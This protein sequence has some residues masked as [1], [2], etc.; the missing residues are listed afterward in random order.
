MKTILHRSLL[1][2]LLLGFAAS[3]ALAQNVVVNGDFQKFTPIDNLWD[4]VD[5]AGFLAGFRRATYATTESGKVGGQEMPISVSFVDVNGDGLPDLITADPAGILRAYINSGTKTEPKFTYAEIIPLFPPQIAK[6]TVYDR[7]W[8]TGPH[9][10]PKIALFDWNHNG[11]ADLLIGNYCGD[12]LLVP[13]TG[14]A[15]GPAFAQPTNYDRVK[16]PL[17]GKRPWG[18]L[19]A[20]CAIDWNK[21]G[22]TDLLIGEGS[23]SA[24][25]VY[26]L[27]NQS[28]GS[29]PKFSDDQR[30]YL[31]YGDG[32]EQLVPTV[33]DYNGDGLPD[34]LVGDRKG[35][36]G[37]YL[38][39]GNWKPGTELPLSEMIRFG[40][41]DTLGMPIAPHAADYNGDGLFDLIIGKSNGRISLALNK[42]TKTQ[43]KFD[44]AVEMRGEKYFKEKI[45]LPGD[46]TFDIGH[47]R[48]NLYAFL[49]VDANEASPGGG[50]VLKAG[51]FP[52]P[53]K[54]FKMQSLAVNGK[55]D[56]DYF[57][58]W[59]EEWVPVDV[60]WAGWN[61]MADAFLMRQ[62]LPELK[63]GTTYKLTFK[64]KGKGITDGA[65][66]VAYLGAAENVAT[67]FVKNERGAAKAQKDETHEEV[68]VTEPFSSGNEWKSM[69]KTFTVGFKEHN[70]KK[71]TGT[72][73]AMI[74]FKFVL[75]QYGSDCEICDVQLVAAPD[76]K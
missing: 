41:Q 48:G 12:V 31:C 5:S 75:P 67:K 71:L 18:N 34:V 38:N 22:K 53:N 7:S 3:G 8:W 68:N 45:N 4:G 29:T 42:G 28:A 24:N 14:S 16:I 66:T 47:D 26:V 74:E 40:N 21:D 61:R 63:I 20:P 33:A 55:D 36:V 49:H 10:V 57:R 60:R 15:S 54:V 72:T 27:L 70:L 32:R 51:Y 2:S 50:K 9:S 44:T 52:S 65:C 25:A 76:K 62:N 6:D 64:V 35:T 30:Y 11:A 13:N 23:Y 58:Y 46:W 56:L 19:F 69:E 59:R 39:P 17:A 1:L 43:P 37:V 73:L